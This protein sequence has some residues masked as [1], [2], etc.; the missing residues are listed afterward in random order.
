MPQSIDLKTPDAPQTASRESL[1]YL[2]IRGWSAALLMDEGLGPISLP[3]YLQW[4]KDATMWHFVT[5][6]LV[7]SIRTAV[8]SC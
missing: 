8:H 3:H 1:L 5:P 7:R 2:C 4:V 6:L